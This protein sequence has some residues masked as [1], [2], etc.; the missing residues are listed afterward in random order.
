LLHKLENLLIKFATVHYSTTVTS[1]ERHSDDDFSVTTRDQSGTFTTRKYNAVIIAAPIEYANLTLKGVEWK[2]PV[3][4]WIPLSLHVVTASSLK[5][6]F[7]GVN[8]KNRVP[9]TLTTTSAVANWT[10]IIP[11]SRTTKGQLVYDV[12]ARA[13]KELPLNDM[14]EN[15]TNHFVKEWDYTYQIL[16]PP[17]HA[18]EY[19]PWLIAHNFLY[20]NAMEQLFSGMEAATM[21]AKNA[22]RYMSY[23]NSRRCNSG[24]TVPLPEFVSKLV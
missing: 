2:Y 13:K 7:F 11:V 12:F 10:T 21:S 22:G 17:K 14:F 4:E 18:S 3:R 23:Q 5:P 6:A 9:D 19:Q 8:P 16:A 15:I 24:C 1:I 20:L